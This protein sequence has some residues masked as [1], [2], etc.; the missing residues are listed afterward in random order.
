M[1]GTD[2]RAFGCDIN[3]APISIA[4]AYHFVNLEIRRRQMVLDAVET[5]LQDA[6]PGVLPLS[7]RNETADAGRIKAALV[8]LAKEQEG[9]P[10]ATLLEALIVLVDFYRPNLDAKR[11]FAVWRQLR[12]K[13]RWL[14]FSKRQVEACQ[15]DAR[16]L[17]LPDRVV[18][19][20][21]TSPPYINVFNYHQ[22][23]RASAEALGWNLL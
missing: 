20:V 7:G 10:A 18:D 3:P 23:Y 1:R 17:P 13:V 12:Q 21:I 19:L 9:L 2:C 22:M 15:A 5:L 16:H 4:R 8:R 14:P 6:I 11:V